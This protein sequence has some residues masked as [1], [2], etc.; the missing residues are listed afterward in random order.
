M[1]VAASESCEKAGRSLLNRRV[2]A[3]GDDG[4]PRTGVVCVAPGMT[5]CLDHCHMARVELK[6]LSS[7]FERAIHRCADS[8]EV[9]AFEGSG[10]GARSVGKCRH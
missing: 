4:A 5:N 8:V 9:P 2:G 3:V 1:D 7:K 10:C 6:E